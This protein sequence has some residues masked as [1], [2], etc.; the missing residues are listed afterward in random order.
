[1]KTMSLTALGVAITIAMSG[2]ATT[3]HGA[4]INSQNPKE[5]LSQAVQ[6]QLRSSFSY[7]TTV[8]ASNQAHRESL[9]NISADTKNQNCE[10][11]HDDAYVQLLKS[12]LGADD[13]TARQT[14]LKDEYMACL[15]EYASLGQYEHFD[16]E[17]FYHDNKTLDAASLNT[18]L[19]TAMSAHAEEQAQKISDDSINPASELD[20][21]KAQLMHEY[22]IKPTKATMT[23][24]YQPLAGVFTALPSV[25]YHAKNVALSINQ[26]IYLDLKSGII[27]LWADN[28]ANANSQI[29]DK[30]LG[31]KWHNKWL[32]IPL[33]DGSLPEG[34]AKDFMRAYLHAKKESFATLDEQSIKQISSDELLS[35][36]Y[37]ADNVDDTTKNL[38]AQ[39]THIIQNA[40]SKKSRAYAQYI[41]ADTLYN[42]ITGKY[43]ELINT[44]TYHAY[45]IEDGE[46]SISISAP[47]NQNAE[48]DETAQ[49]ASPK[50][51]SKTFVSLVLNFLQAR[52]HQYY[53]GLSAEEGETANADHQ[54]I[55]HYGVQSG[56]ISWLHQRQYLTR[57]IGYDRFNINTSKQPAFVDIIT[58][59]NDNSHGSA[60]DRLPSNVRT[61]N[62]T[63]SINV[64]DY[65]NEFIQKLQS[66]DS[67]NNPLMNLLL[68]SNDAQESLD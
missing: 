22:L 48:P 44:P 3:N 68:N 54:P 40:P 39:S 35:L 34:F 36:P 47:I 2:C 13:I 29:L 61:P 12:G 46:S 27:Y 43:P 1:M 53:A 24:H 15:E 52:V 21:K 57:N 66:D 25:S 55:W 20:T 26:P 38:I 8:Y 45:D 33:N 51:T 18:A 10:Q 7:Q 16:F 49:E 65:G 23:G 64:F 42:E 67:S 11:V 30:T 4:P 31:D 41:F 32:A 5:T 59:I 6:S 56:Q 19:T 37:F 62:D 58:K 17:Q 60:F 63:N 50:I 9:T 14:Q 28:F